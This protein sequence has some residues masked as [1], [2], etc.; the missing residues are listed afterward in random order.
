MGLHE[1]PGSRGWSLVSIV[2]RAIIKAR[3][4]DA[5]PSN[6][7]GS[8]E[9]AQRVGAP[10][11][12]METHAFE[13]QHS[14]SMRAGPEDAIGALWA[15]STDES[16]PSQF[17]AIRREVYA[18]IQAANVSDHAPLILVTSALPADGKTFVSVALARALASAPDHRATLLDVDVIRRSSSALFGAERLRGV[19]ECLQQGVSLPEV[20]AATG[21]PRLS[22]VPAGSLDGDNRELFMGDGM[23]RL[24]TSLRATGPRNYCILDA[25]P[26]LPVVE[27]ALLAAKVD[28]VILVIRAGVTPQRAVLDAL[29]KLDPSIKVCLVMNGVN[30]AHTGEYYDYYSYSR[31][32]GSDK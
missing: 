26:L 27:T 19:L 12:S 14:V 28:L 17:R 8:R 3:E 29:A 31:S 9:E 2:E 11:G 7:L 4:E 20:V 18:Q 10:R 5:R 25:P 15:R 23:S 30:Q 16:I 24:V 32:T 13:P 6:A 21:V 22:F 1:V